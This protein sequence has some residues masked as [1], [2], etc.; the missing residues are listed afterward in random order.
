MFSRRLL[1]IA[2]LVPVHSSV[3]DVG[4]DHGLLD[5]YLTLHRNCK[6]IAADVNENCLKNARENI[7]KYSLTEKIKVV[8]SDGLENV[9]YKKND[10]VIIAG[11]G[12]NTILKILEKHDLDNVIIQTNTDLFEFRETITDKYIIEDEKVI[13]ERGIYYVIMKL[14]RGYKKYKYEDFIVGPIIKT[15]DEY[16]DYREFLLEKYSSIYKSVPPSNFNKKIEL[17]LIV[18]SIKKYCD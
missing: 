7:R 6:C 5:I 4:C 18:K 13:K 9:K 12:T 10:Y 8:T 17:R 11:M 15:K 1:E 16:S 14:K 2:S 3:I